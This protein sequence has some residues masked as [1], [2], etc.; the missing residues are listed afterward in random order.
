MGGGAGAA[1]RARPLQR[2]SPRALPAARDQGT[3]DR[4]ATAPAR[5]ALPA[6]RRGVVES[7]AAA[8][9][10][11][12]ELPRVPAPALEAREVRSALVERAAAAAN[13]QVQRPGQV[14]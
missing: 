9:R 2:R 12:A 13:A 10:R 7:T 6:P 4:A 3:E 5:A 8:A 11:A 14:L 1:R